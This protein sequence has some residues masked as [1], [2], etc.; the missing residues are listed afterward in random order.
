MSSRD[1][2][3]ILSKKELPSRFQLPTKK[4]QV[5]R[6]KAGE[7]PF[8]AKNNADEDDIF[9]LDQEGDAQTITHM[10][11]ANPEQAH[12]DQKMDIEDPT[13]ESHI[14][15]EE[16]ND[17]SQKIPIIE[18]KTDNREEMRKALLA[19]EDKEDSSMDCE[20]FFGKEE[21]DDQSHSNLNQVHPS[22]FPH[23]SN[24]LNHS[25]SESNPDS[26]SNSGNSESEEE[27]E[28][29]AKPVFVKKD[30]RTLPEKQA[31]EE[32]L[33]KEEKKRIEETRRKEVK[34]I[35]LESSMVCPPKSLY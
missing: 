7:V 35:L 3:S 8:W 10:T 19:Q 25:Q 14:E 15:E 26:N 4:P 17:K 12:F 32:I 9:A 27:P 6:Y 13:P 33:F 18:V 24:N 34:K 31:T 22:T 11:V 1:P 30:L 2:F 5:Q 21:N 29:R 23:A 16:S 28:I 20:N